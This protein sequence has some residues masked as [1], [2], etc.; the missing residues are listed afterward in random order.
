[1]TNIEALLALQDHDM[2][3]ADIRRELHDLPA[4]KKI[5]LQ[6]LDQHKKSLADA[7][8]DLKAKQTEIKQ[9]EI[10]IETQRGKISK[11]RQQQLDIKTNKE[12]K[13]I[14]SEI[15]SVQR[16]IAGLEDK[17]LGLME[18][19]ERIQQDIAARKTDLEAED[20]AVAADVRVFDERAAELEQECKVEEE[21]RAEAARDVDPEWLER[22]DTIR[23]RRGNA[24]VKLE[25]GVCSGCHMQLPPAALHDTRNDKTMTTCDFCGRLLYS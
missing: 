12:F 11:F 23:V 20:K 21:R 17:E 13:A 2:R 6:R 7:Q 3:V 22:Y 24:L 10:E 1:V 25:N 9:L 18:E 8:E 16:T 14:E 5:E 4:R 19:L 15:K